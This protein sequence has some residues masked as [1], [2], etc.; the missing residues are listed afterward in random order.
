MVFRWR[1]DTVRLGETNIHGQRF[2]SLD[3]LPDAIFHEA[4][5]EG[6]PRAWYRH[7]FDQGAIL[8]TAIER[9]R[10]LGSVWVLNAARVGAWYVPLE[11]DAQVIYGVVTPA[12]ARGRGVAAQLSLAAARGAG[13]VPVYLDCMAWN[14]PAQRAFAKAG[15]VPVAIAG[16]RWREAR[17]GPDA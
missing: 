2:A 5:P 8:W 15:F 1:P 9:G 12:W 14:R 3:D 6:Q 17:A 11:A 10:A 4:D 7:F 13:G 16:S